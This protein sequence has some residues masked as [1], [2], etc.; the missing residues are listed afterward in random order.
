MILAEAVL[1]LAVARLQHI[2][3]PFDRLVK[4]FGAGQSPVQTEPETITAP[5][6]T[7][8]QLVQTVKW[9]VERAARDVPF[10]AVCL[11]QAMAA[12]AMLNRR[13]IDSEM[14]FG[15]LRKPDGSLAAH[16]WLSVGQ[17]EVTGFPLEPGL[18]EMT[19]FVP[20]RT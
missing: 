7:E 17:L 11:Q 13:R 18:V 2:A 4:K 19:R 12:H 5:S 3:V 15:V 6:E 16:A 1:S 10:R 20:G 14:H 8:R 9:A